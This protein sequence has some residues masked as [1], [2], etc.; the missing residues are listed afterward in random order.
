M[1][2][3]WYI[4]VDRRTDRTKLMSP[5]RNYVNAP[6]NTDTQYPHAPKTLRAR[7][8]ICA[9]R[10]CSERW[11]C[12][13]REARSCHVCLTVSFCCPT[14]NITLPYEAS[15]FLRVCG[16]CEVTKLSLRLTNGAVQSSRAVLSGLHAL[17]R[18]FQAILILSDVRT[19]RLD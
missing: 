2:L 18:T 19:P 1:K 5:N 17:K 14:G 7:T 13:C 16:V 3:Q 12:R 4:C 6:R 11:H 8:T 9:E 10:L 15:S